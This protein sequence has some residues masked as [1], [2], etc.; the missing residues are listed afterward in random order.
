[1]YDQNDGPSRERRVLG[2]SFVKMPRHLPLIEL[3]FYG[4]IEKDMWK[5]KDKK[6]IF[7]FWQRYPYHLALPPEAHSSYGDNSKSVIETLIGDENYRRKQIMKFKQ[8]DDDV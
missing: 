3:Y 6:K 4:R 8:G 1:M 2:T 5:G 7:S